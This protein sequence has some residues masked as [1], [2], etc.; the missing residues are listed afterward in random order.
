MKIYYENSCIDTHSKPAYNK[1]KRIYRKE[2]I[3]AKK[4]ANDVYNL[5]SNNKCKAAWKLIKSETMET[6]EK[7]PIPL[8]PEEL[9]KYFI[10]IGNLSISD[11]CKVSGN[12]ENAGRLLDSREDGSNDSLDFS[13]ENCLP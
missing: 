2:R 7:L 1:Q 13:V 8:S 6:T 4:K 12:N 9:N 11:D 5:Q 3:N 10:N